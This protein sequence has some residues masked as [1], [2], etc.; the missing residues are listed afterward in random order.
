MEGLGPHRGEDVTLIVP[1]LATAFVFVILAAV[2]VNIHR[3]SMLAATKTS[4]LEAREESRHF[5][6]EMNWETLIER[7]SREWARGDVLSAIV[8]SHR[9]LVWE[10]NE[11]GLILLY[12]GRAAL[13]P[14]GLTPEQMEGSNLFSDWKADEASGRAVREALSTGLSVDWVTKPQE[15]TGGA[16]WWGRAVPIDH[17]GKRVVR[18]VGHTLEVLGE[19]A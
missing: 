9:M 5:N 3:Y 14:F 10:V 7:A 8:N 15:I 4:A 12:K 19:Q 18:V 11:D 13:E 17:H 2:I 1:I 16:I 6:E